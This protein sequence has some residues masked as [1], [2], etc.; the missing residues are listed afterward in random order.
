MMHHYTDRSGYNAIRAAQ[1][2]HFK[3]RKP[4]GRHPVGAYFTNLER[5]TPKLAKRLRIPRTKVTYVFIF[6]DIGDLTPLPGDRGHYIFFSPREY[7]V[8]QVRQQYR[9][10][11]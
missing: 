10:P 4:P 9:G 2:W 3:A 7:D 6:V 11:T 1:R 8:D 5:G